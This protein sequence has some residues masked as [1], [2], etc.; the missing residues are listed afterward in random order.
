MYKIQSVYIVIL[1]YVLL[2]L[3]VEC[4]HNGSALSERQYLSGKYS[5]I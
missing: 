2:V 5:N 4:D 1:S 3:L